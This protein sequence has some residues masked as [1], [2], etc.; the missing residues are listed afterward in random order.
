MMTSKRSWRGSCVTFEYIHKGRRAYQENDKRRSRSHNIVKYGMTQGDVLHCFVV[1]KYAPRVILKPLP[2]ARLLETRKFLD[3]VRESIKILSLPVFWEELIDWKITSILSKHMRCDLWPRW[4]YKRF[5]V[6]PTM[7]K[8]VSRNCGT[9]RT[10]SMVCCAQLGTRKLW[11][12]DVLTSDAT[13]SVTYWM[14]ISTCCELYCCPR[15]FL[16]HGRS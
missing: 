15:D 13:T 9:V 14:P 12:C 6:W 11:W 8:T 5:E 10:R 1:Y 3:L 7:L 4:E 16:Y 2:I